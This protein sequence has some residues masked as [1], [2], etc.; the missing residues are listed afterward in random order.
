MQLGDSWL[1]GLPTPPRGMEPLPLTWLLPAPPRGVE[2]LPLTWV[3]P[4]PPR[5]VDP[6]PLTCL[7]NVRSER[8]RDHSVVSLV[9]ALR[10]LAENSV[11]YRYQS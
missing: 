8:A 2:P 7:R 10:R 5:G 3:L 6:L 9:H 4:A 1:D 11:K